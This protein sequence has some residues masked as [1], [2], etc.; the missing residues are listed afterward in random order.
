MKT[1][2]L[3][4]TERVSLSQHTTALRHVVNTGNKVIETRNGSNKKRGRK[5]VTAL[6]PGKLR[7]G[8]QIEYQ[9]V[10]MYQTSGSIRRHCT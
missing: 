8:L 6:G 2:A 4:Q 9:R 1:E 7:R 10:Q 5:H 3:L